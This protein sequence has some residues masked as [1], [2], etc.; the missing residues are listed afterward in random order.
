MMRQFFIPF[1]NLNFPNKHRLHMDNARPHVAKHTREF[2]NS[3]NINHFKSP[4]QSPDLN[5]IELVWQDLKVFLGE[6]VKPN[7]QQEL[8]NGINLFWNTKVT[9]QYCNDKID[10]LERVLKTV[11]QKGGKATGM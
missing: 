5:P 8:V 3:N 10:H 6:E 9:V 11:I 1:K 4:A 7:N 2:L